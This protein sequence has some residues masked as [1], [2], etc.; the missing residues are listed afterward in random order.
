MRTLFSSFSNLSEF[1]ST[2]CAVILCLTVHEY[3]HGLVAYKLGDPTAKDAGRLTLNPIA[4]IDPVGFICMILF[5]FGWARPV[6]VNVRYFRQPR[7]DMALVAAAGPASNLVFGFVSVFAYYLTALYAPGTAFFS[8]LATFLATLAVLNVSLAVFNLLPAPPLDGSRI[9][10]LFLPAN[11]YWQI[12]RYEQYIK[13]GVMILLYFGVLT[14]PMNILRV[15]VM[16]GMEAVVRWI[17]L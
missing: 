5:R 9:A 7:R 11:W 8:A 14:R 3:C 10:G 16:D 1:I 17:L 13:W 2:F 15:W 4:H 6:P 12:M